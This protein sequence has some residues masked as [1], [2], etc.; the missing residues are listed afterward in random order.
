M[1]NHNKLL[2]DL[3]DMTIDVDFNGK[4]WL[5]NYTEGDLFELNRKLIN[6]N[7]K[8]PIVWLQSGY[9]VE[10]NKQGKQ[11]TLNGCK[12]FFITKG[13]PTDR[14]EKRYNNTYEKLLYPAL[15]KFDKLIN[16]TKGLEASNT[17]NFTTFPFNDTTELSR[18]ETSSGAK[19]STQT[20]T[21]PDIWDA[22]LLETT[23]T[24]SDNCFSQLKIN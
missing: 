5:I 23:I 6:S 8:Y 10:R 1:I 24:I 20:I 17:D 19:S 22:I 13:S 21:V 9:R 14:Y 3:L 4:T 2:Y 12:F 16:K 15:V 7:T 11:T 18:R